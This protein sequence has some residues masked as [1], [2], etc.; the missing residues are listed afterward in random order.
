MLT[1]NK[2][3][4]TYNVI[5]VNTLSLEG[6]VLALISDLTGRKLLDT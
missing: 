6:I 2:K 5:F 3:E 1:H 4:E